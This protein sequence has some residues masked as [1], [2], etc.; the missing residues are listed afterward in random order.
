[1]NSVLKE[2]EYVTNGVDSKSV[3]KLLT[4]IAYQTKNIANELTVNI[5]EH[6]AKDLQDYTNEISKT[7]AT[8]NEKT[9]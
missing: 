7:L 3:E 6:I 4:H 1:M 8:L 2:N 5:N 9:I